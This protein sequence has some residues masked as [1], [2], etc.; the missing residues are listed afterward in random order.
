[1]LLPRKI[2]AICALLFFTVACKKNNDTRQND[3]PSGGTNTGKSTAVGATIG[4]AE[5]KVIGAAGGSFTTGD[6]RL[7]V[8]FPA[9]ALNGD[10]TI[11]IQPITNNTPGGAG[12]AYRISPHDINFSQPVKI[13]FSYGD[14]DL[15]NTLPN[16]LAIAYQDAKGIWQAVGGIINDTA[17]RKISITTTHF[18]DW[19]LFKQLILVPE[20]GFVD[21]NGSITASVWRTTEVDDLVV[22]IGNSPVNDSIAAD[23]KQWSLAGAGTLVPN[24]NEAVYTA[25]ATMPE[26]NPVAISAE[27]NTGKGKYLLV[28]NIYVGPEGVTFRVDN[29]AWVH[30]VSP[31]GVQLFGDKRFF[32]AAVP[33]SPK[34]GEGISI[35]WEGH[36]KTNQEIPWTLTYPNFQYSYKLNGDDITSK[37]YSVPDGNP[38][39]GGLT[40]ISNVESP[41]IM[42]WGVFDVRK[43]GMVWI[44]ADRTRVPGFSN[45]RIEGFFKIKWA[46]N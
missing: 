26:R 3:T 16:A 23:I 6:K 31:G 45:H 29:G 5:T 15:K 12:T 19:S 10:H 43:S 14:D 27:L 44:Y 24:K 20:I 41:G 36:P 17:A 13:S 11:S 28:S 35:Y 1:M 25:P 2:L 33:N 40:F 22:P 8:D 42:Q 39:P 46:G 9:G 30:A 4:N 37:Q 34:F 32:T 18:S 7:T 21:L 38:S